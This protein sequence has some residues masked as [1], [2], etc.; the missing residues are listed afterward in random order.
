MSGDWHN[1]CASRLLSSNSGV[2]RSKAATAIVMKIL[3][4]AR[5]VRAI[6]APS[7][8]AAH[9]SLSRDARRRPLASEPVARSVFAVLQTATRAESWAGACRPFVPLVLRMDPSKLSG[10]ASSRQ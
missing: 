10:F 9:P 4:S 2:S 6:T 8:V 3:N 7:N 1:Q 5:R